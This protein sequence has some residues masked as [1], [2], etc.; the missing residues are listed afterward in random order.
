[1]SYKFYIKNK[2]ERQRIRDEVEQA[3]LSR[4]LTLEQREVSRRRLQLDGYIK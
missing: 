2:E 1:M 4:V 3:R